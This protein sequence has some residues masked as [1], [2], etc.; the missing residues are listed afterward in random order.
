[1][2]KNRD[3]PAFGSYVAQ[4]NAM[5]KSQMDHKTIQASAAIR[6]VTVL[7]RC[8]NTTTEPSA[9]SWTK[10]TTP[11]DM[12]ESAKVATSFRRMAARPFDYFNKSILDKPE[13]VDQWAIQRVEA[14]IS[15]DEPVVFKRMVNTRQLYLIG[16]RVADRVAR[17]NSVPQPPLPLDMSA[18]IVG[19]DVSDG[20]VRNIHARRSQKP[21]ANSLPELSAQ[22]I[23]TIPPP[24]P[25][26]NPVPFPSEP[27]AQ[28]PELTCFT[29][30]DEP[31]PSDP[32]NNSPTQY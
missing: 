32:W 3:D 5:I 12:E 22:P 19:T 20:T 2:I 7:T 15:P 29:V 24:P 27:T 8:I 4:L 21:K 31:L 14:A 16:E 18:P 6:A 10:L 30:W 11:P 28:T 25:V 1:L 9:P 17:S 23:T 13:F 26:P